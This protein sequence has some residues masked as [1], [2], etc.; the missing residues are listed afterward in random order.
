MHVEV[1]L[2]RRGSSGS[3]GPSGLKYADKIS[4]VGWGEAWVEE[5]E[6]GKR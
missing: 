6:A 5:Q 1:M 3:S 4:G 2:G